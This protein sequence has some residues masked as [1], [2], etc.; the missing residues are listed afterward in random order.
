MLLKQ[1]KEEEWMKNKKDNIRKEIGYKI[2]FIRNLRGI[3]TEDFADKLGISRS[4]L[5][6]YEK[7]LT[8]IKISKLYEISQL[9][10]V[11]LDFFFE[12]NSALAENDNNFD[13]NILTKYNHIKDDKIK[14]AV[15]GLVK[16]LSGN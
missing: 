7:G 5:Q 4:Q 1:L 8:D 16:E 9:M 12:S 14:E 13:F 6:N 11:E 10:N 3:S 2:K 15:Y